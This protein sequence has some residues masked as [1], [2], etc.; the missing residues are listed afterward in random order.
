[1]KTKFF[2]LGLV[3]L[4]IVVPG[5]LLMAKGQK[6]KTLVSPL[7]ASK[8]VANYEEKQRSIS[9]YITTSQEFLNKARN[10]A[11]DTNQT[12]EEKQKIIT[13]INQA[14]D[15]GNQAIAFYAND[16]RGFSQRA[17]IYQALIPFLPES[18]NFAIQD[19]KEAIKLNQQN[20]E[21][22]SRL[23]NLY[24][25]GGNFENAALSFYNAHMLAPTEVQT[26]YNLADALEKSG[27]LKKANHFFEKLI[28]LL[29][30][31]DQN[32]QTIQ[33]R[34]QQLETVLVQ[35]N[36]EYLTEPGASDF[37]PQGGA[38]PTTDKIIG[39][40]ELPLEQAALASQVIIA[41]P[42][43]AANVGQQ[44]TT[45]AINAKTGTGVIPA[46]QTEVTIKNNHVANDKQIVLVA[47]SDT[48]NKVLFLKA[49]KEDTW[50]KAGIDKPINNNLE[51]KWWIID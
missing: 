3:V 37:A 44:T 6:P 8:T 1:M 32:L 31:D 25:N 15:L 12:P 17:N 50:F 16:D 22:H 45:L 29:P 46:G 27:Q 48:K 2:I 28:G 26:L 47:T 19:L 10:L 35:A 14:L 21:Y 42:E 5:I 20:P 24:L 40:Q 18:A 36:L 30:S 4:A 13:T 23:A 7:P 41:G 51:F 11:T 43:E 34:Q 49:K 38:N 9:Y 33:N 39:T